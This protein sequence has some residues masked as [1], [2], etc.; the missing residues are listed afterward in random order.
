VSWSSSTNRRTA[1]PSSSSGQ[2]L[3]SVRLSGSSRALYAGGGWPTHDV[4]LRA[5]A[6]GQITVRSSDGDAVG[7]VDR[8]RAGSQ[9]HSGASYLHAGRCWTVTDLDLAAG[10]AWVEPDDGTTYTVAR[11]HTDLTVTEVVTQRSLEADAPPGLK[12]GRGW[13]EVRQK[14]VGYQRKEVGSGR[15]LASES[16]DLPPS[17]L[18]TTA[19]WYSVDEDL[20]Q[21]AGLTPDRVPGTLHAVEHAGIGVL[22]LFAICDRWDVGGV[23]TAHQ[24]E[25]GQAA[26]V[27]YDG[28]EGGAGVAAVMAVGMQ[29]WSGNGA[30][31]MTVLFRRTRF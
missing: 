15:I 12:V 1:S 8:A 10:V 27:I 22:P 26:I 6:A 9:V 21:R 31:A 23:S 14:V 11:S 16:L 30:S 2:Y 20:L 29:D 5:G 24:A 18:R 17:T 25:L 13:V 19:F 3:S 7:T 28:Y 4:S